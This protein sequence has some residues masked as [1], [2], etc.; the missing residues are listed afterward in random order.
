MQSLHYQWP[1]STP[2]TVML[3]SQEKPLPDAFPNRTIWSEM[4]FRCT[5]SAGYIMFFIITVCLC[6]WFYGKRGSVEMCPSCGVLMHALDV[7]HITLLP[8]AL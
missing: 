4:F 3:Q 2:D 8:H 7:P 1:A 5:L 6:I